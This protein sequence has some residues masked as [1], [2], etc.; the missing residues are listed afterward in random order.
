MQIWSAEIKELESLYTSIKGRF[1]ELEKE[2]GQLIKFDDPNVILLYS[3]RCL[4]V[5]ISDLSINE[6]KKSRKTE[7]L[8]GIID[9]LNH[10]EK[11]PEYI[12]TSMHSLNDLSTFGAHPKV[13]DPE[14]VKPAL[15]NLDIIL[16]WYLKYKEFIGDPKGKKKQGIFGRTVHISW[17]K[18]IAGILLLLILIVS[19]ILVYPKLFKV[20]NLEKLQSSGHKI[21][22][23]VMPFQ[24]MTNDST[25]DIWQDGIQ[26]ELITS[27]TNSEEL[28]IRQVESVNNLIQRKGLANYASITPSFAS[29]ISQK[30]EADVFVVGSL[31]KAGNIIRVNA[32]LNDSKTKETFKSFQIDGSPENI[33]KIS[34]SLSGLVRNSLIISKLEQQLPVYDQSRPLT[35]SSEAYRYYLYGENARKKRDFPTALN[36]YRQALAIDSNYTLVILKISVAYMNQGLYEESKEWGLKAYQRRDQ[37]PL[38]LKILI[39][40]NHAFFFETPNEEVKCLRQLLEIDDI[41]P[42]TYYDIGLAYMGAYEYDKAIPEFEK[43]LEIYKKFDCKPWWVY[44]YSLLGES[45]HKTGQYKKE[46][47]LYR[48]ADKDFPN[49]PL[50]IY[51]KAILSLTEKDTIAANNY[52]NQYISLSAEDASSEEF[53]S[54]G[55]AEFYIEAGNLEKAEAYLRQEFSKQPENVYRIYKLAMFLIDKERNVDEGLE[56]IEKALASRPDLKWYLLDCKG[57]GLYKKG[58]FDEALTILQECWDSRIY[59][60]HS[61]FLHLEAARKAVE[62][63]KN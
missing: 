12:I 51:L 59:Y 10:E 35:G 7:P 52:L 32:Q 1:P 47:K 56:L 58:K 55:P 44:N 21:T 49:D 5:I 18:L 54:I 25:M 14:Q 41:F 60:Q 11:V 3:R 29:I 31:K 50:I 38:K 33:L 6:L 46:K 27:L 4:E 37:V 26:N 22:V 61:I 42:G 43:S 9:K 48:Q 13:F 34:D 28:K 45:Y 62:R 36:M 2:L 15:L 24:N 17:K 19:G 57:W 30:L 20:N 53:V 40:K 39:N 63:L 16:K 23:A 8:K